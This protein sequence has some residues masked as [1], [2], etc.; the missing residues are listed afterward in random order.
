[1]EPPYTERYVRWCERS[2]VNR[3][4]LLDLGMLLAGNII[5]IF[6]VELRGVRLEGAEVRVKQFGVRFEA[7]EVRLGAIEVRWE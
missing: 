6:C 4:L 7:N 5:Y 2:G 3:S 1:I